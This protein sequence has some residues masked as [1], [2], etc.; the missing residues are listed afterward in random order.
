MFLPWQKKL[1]GRYGFKRAGNEAAGIAG[2]CFAVLG[3]ARNAKTLRIVFPGLDDEDREFTSRLLSESKVKKYQWR[4]REINI[5]FPEYVVPYAPKKIAALLDSVTD[6]FAKKYPGQNHA[7][8][9]CG[10]SAACDVYAGSGALYLCENCFS[11]E[12]E[13][14]YQARREY[15][16]TPGNYVPGFAGALLFAIPGVLLAVAFFVFLDTIAA[17]STVFC[18][19]LAQKGYTRF[20]GKASPAGAF[21]VNAAGIVMTMAGIFAGY[22]VYIVRFLLDQGLILDDIIPVLGDILAIAE[23]RAELVK[24]VLLALGISSVYIVMNVFKTMKTWRFPEIRKAEA[25]P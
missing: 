16:E 18:M 6:H 3:D 21:L 1:G 13:N 25:I 10:T 20:K 17:A 23:L 24:N 15:D 19:V 11:K 14:L 22:T 5:T 8:H 12:E 7:C 9:H 2:N 4:E